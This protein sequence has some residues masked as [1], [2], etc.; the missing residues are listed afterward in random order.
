MSEIK[1]N[2]DLDLE[3]K[4][5]KDQLD[6]FKKSVKDTK[7]PVELDISKVKQDAHG[8]KNILSDAFKIDSKTIGDLE[9]IGNALKQINKLIKN[10]ND[11]SKKGGNSRDT[12]VPSFMASALAP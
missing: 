4:K 1:I 7:I 5:A 11:L 3:T 2:V 12:F 9:Q 6:N 8:L 10:Q